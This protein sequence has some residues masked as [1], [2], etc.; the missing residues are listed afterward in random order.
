[1]SDWRP[2]ETAPQDGSLVIVWAAQR[3]GLPGFVTCCSYHPDGGWC[4]CELREVTLW[5]PLP[6]APE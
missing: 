2:I 6:E 5:Q 3:E 1:M 4:V